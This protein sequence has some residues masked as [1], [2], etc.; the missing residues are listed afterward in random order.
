MS[1][2]FEKGQEGHNVWKEE[3]YSHYIVRRLNSGGELSGLDR[4]LFVRRVCEEKR[5][6][7][8][9]KYTSIIFHNTQ[10]QHYEKMD[11]CI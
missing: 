5:N 11:D 9:S 4:F 8:E 7:Y 1:Q 10:Y 6:V 3:V 2:I